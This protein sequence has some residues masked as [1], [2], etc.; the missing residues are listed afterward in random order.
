MTI[1]QD[2]IDQAKRV[3]LVALVQAKGIKL[4]TTLPA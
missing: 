1:G 4:Q 3:D 2:I